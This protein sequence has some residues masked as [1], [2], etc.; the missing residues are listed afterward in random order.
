MVALIIVDL[1]IGVFILRLT[2]GLCKSIEVKIRAQEYFGV[3]LQL[4]WHC[5][6]EIELKA[7]LVRWLTRIQRNMEALNKVEE[8]SAAEID[9]F[10]CQV[11]GIFCNKVLK[12]MTDQKDDLRAH[13]GS[14]EGRPGNTPCPAGQHRVK[15]SDLRCGDMKG[16]TRR[17]S[18]LHRIEIKHKMALRR[19]PS[20]RRLPTS[21]DHNRYCDFHQDHG[22]TMGECHSLKSELEG[23]TQKGMLNDYISNKDQQAPPHLPPPS[24]IIHMITGELEV[25]GTSLKQQKLYVREVMGVELL[26]NRPDDEAR[27]TPI[28]ELEEVELDDNDP[29]KKTQNGTKLDSKEREELINLLKSNKDVFDW[30][31]ADMPG[32]P[33][34]VIVHKLSIDPL[35]KPVAKKRCL[36]GGERLQ[37][38]REEVQKL[39]QAGFDY[40]PLPSIDKLVEAASGNERLSLLDAYSGYHQVHIA[41]ED[42]VKTSFCVSDEIYCYVMMPFGLKNAG[43]TYQKKVKIVFQAQIDKNLEVYVDDIVVKSLKAEDHLTDLGETFDN[44]RKHSMK[45]NLAKCVFEVE[46]GK[47]LGLLVSKRGMEV[48]LEKI[49]ATEEIKPPKSIKDV[50]RLTRRVAALHQF[51]SKVADRCLPFFKVLRSATQKDEAGKP[52]KFECTFERQTSFDELKAYL[53]SPP[54][55]TKVEEGEILYLYLGISDTTVSS[56][57]IREMGQLQKPVYYASKILQKLECSGRLIKW[58]VE[59]GEFHITFQQRS[60]I[61]AQ[62]LA[63]FVVECTFNQGNTNFEVELWT[64]YVDGASNSKGSS[65][66]PVLIGLENFQS[67]H[68]LKFNFEATNNMAEYEAFLLGVCLAAELKVRF[69]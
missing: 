8:E 29:I 9:Q 15:R 46:S 5:L 11:G 58:A 54:L 26:D 33:T 65:V 3:L 51:I 27:A 69:L 7:L 62:T 1:S 13:A 6:W 18:K 39:L 40:H 49:K 60:S 4:H 32:I 14:L 30:T 47:F 37:A 21:K 55:L 35:K 16:R 66:G 53:S 19:L 68:A 22:H 48:N 44:L 59:L 23:L 61:R 17:D 64:L 50:Q 2:L 41:L 10:I 63:D 52:K 31:S 57:L 20:M 67:E 24:R 45:L 28:E 12:L 38:I 42:E 36:F 43:A 34:S 56:F 25:G